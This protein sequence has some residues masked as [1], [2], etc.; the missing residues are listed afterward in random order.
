MAATEAQGLPVPRRG[1]SAGCRWPSPRSCASARAAQQNN[2]GSVGLCQ[3]GGGGGL[4]GDPHL[5]CADGKCSPSPWGMAE[6]VSTGSLLASKLGY[7]SGLGWLQ[8]AEPTPCTASLSGLKELCVS[9][10]GKGVLCQESASPRHRLTRKVGLTQLRRSLAEHW[11]LFL[12]NI[13]PNQHFKEK[14]GLYQASEAK[15]CPKSMPP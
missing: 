15:L 3:A 8:E 6:E 4:H 5:C 13:F 12:H 14:P 9:S 7:P 1:G 2:P 11:A 10:A